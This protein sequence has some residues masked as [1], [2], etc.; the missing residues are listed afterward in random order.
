MKDLFTVGPVNMFERT[1]K[2][3][4][5]PIPYFRNEYFSNVMFEIFENMGKAVNAPLGSRII[6]LTTSGS[7]GMESAV[8][9]LCD[10]DSTAFVVNGG[11]FG[12]R[13]SEICDRHDIKH[14]DCDV[15]FDEDLTIEMMRKALDHRKIDV[16]FVNIHETSIGKKYETKILKDFAEE[17]GAIL[18]V[19][20]ISSFL[21]DEID[22]SEM[23]AD[24][25]ITASQKAL[26]L[27][28]GICIMVL[29]PR[30]IDA[31]NRV[32]CKD[33]YLGLQGYLKDAERGQTPFTPAIGII[34]TLQD[35]LKCIIE[36]GVKNEI[37]RCKMLA[38][39]FRK[40]IGKLP[41]QVPK[42]NLSNC[43]TPI[44]FNNNEAQKLK[45]FLVK[46]YDIYITPSGG[47][48]AENLA[49][50]GH[51]GNHDI[52]GLDRLIRAMEDYYQI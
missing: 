33:L 45:D 22:M 49:R 35:R 7:G 48:N 43:L 13:F 31:V 4:A 29:S 20:A 11:S 36:H 14:I 51:I 27:D 30:A 50:I 5:Q 42:Y 41:V 34:M 6:L 28:A 3:A 9:N 47:R 46:K 52:A 10:R 26:A 23:G 24:I 1:L 39:Y 18:V 16:I 44:L 15:P 19:D 32:K 2:I 37:D 12:K 25:I 8:I 17:T 38:E 40:N 21:A